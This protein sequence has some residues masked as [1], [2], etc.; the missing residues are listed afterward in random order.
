MRSRKEEVKEKFTLGV[1][2]EFQIVDPNTRELSPQNTEIIRH[3]TPVLGDDV[4]P[5]MLMSCVETVTPICKDI[6]DVR[7]HFRRNRT[8]LL[9]AAF[10]Q[11]VA[12]GAAGTHP[13]SNWAQQ[14]ITD[15]ER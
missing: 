9:E 8:A 11:G 7:E 12:I 13:I 5:E 10:K 15:D 6:H 3:L 14:P 1:E 2:E 4:K